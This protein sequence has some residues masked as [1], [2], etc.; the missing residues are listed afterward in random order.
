VVASVWARLRLV[1]VPQ[2]LATAAA[3]SALALILLK[4]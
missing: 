2:L 1:G 3:F 4:R